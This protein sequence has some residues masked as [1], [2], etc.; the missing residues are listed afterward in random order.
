MSCFAGKSR[1]LGTW[2]VDIVSFDINLS[3]EEWTLLKALAERIKF[4]LRSFKENSSESFQINQSS[5]SLHKL[6]QVFFCSQEFNFV[7]ILSPTG[8]VTLFLFTETNK[9]TSNSL[10]SHGLTQIFPREKVKSEKKRDLMRMN[11]VVVSSRSRSK[12]S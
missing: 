10:E 11:N 8:L 5:H 12:K 1:L 2:R 3:R 9:V 6:L 4:V 7:S